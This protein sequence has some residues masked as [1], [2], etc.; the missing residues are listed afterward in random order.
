MDRNEGSEE[1]AISACCCCCIAQETNCY[2]PSG[3][4]EFCGSASSYY[5][6]MCCCR[7]TTFACICPGH[8]AFEG[9]SKERPDVCCV[10][11]QSRNIFVKPNCLSGKEPCFKAVTKSGCLTTRYSFP[12]DDDAPG[13]CNI[14]PC[15]FVPCCG[16][17]GGCCPKVPALSEKAFGAYEVNYNESMAGDVEYLI[18]AFCLPFCTVCS[19]FVPDKASDV[20]GSEEASSCLCIETNSIQEVLPEVEGPAHEELVIT[21]MMNCMCIKPSNCFKYQRRCLCLVLKGAFP[22][23]ADVPCAMACYG[24]NCCTI[25]VK[26]EFKFSC[27]G[28]DGKYR[29]IYCCEAAKSCKCGKIQ[30]REDVDGDIEAI[31]TP[32]INAEPKG[33]T[34]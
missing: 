2:T 23:D 18:N 26:P 8:P 28:G 20:F 30:A 15:C 13:R 32:V 12:M 33:S 11:Y 25:E 3:C 14:L 16:T 21:S 19:M 5:I 34:P 31:A 1:C 29:S 9:L 17:P 27:C 24:L 10:G 4:A 6:G 7:L 22:P